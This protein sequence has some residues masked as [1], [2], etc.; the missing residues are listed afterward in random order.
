[1][2]F[3][4]FRCVDYWL[5]LLSCKS[6][7]QNLFAISKY[8][9]QVEC[10]LEFL[11]KTLICTRILKLYLNS[12]VKSLKLSSFQPLQYICKCIKRIATSIKV[13]LEAFGEAFLNDTFQMNRVHWAVLCVI[14]KNK[15]QNSFHTPGEKMNLFFFV[16]ISYSLKKAL[17]IHCEHQSKNEA[18]VFFT[19]F[20][21]YLIIFMHSKKAR[22]G[23]TNLIYAKSIKGWKR[24]K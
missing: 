8:L 12:E 5:Y 6:L 23:P 19:F 24:K 1:M 22:A 3:I 15:Q 16:E 20:R 18:F 2:K 10:V 9:L 4:C 14:Y 7:S 21:H 11:I 13:S 17:F